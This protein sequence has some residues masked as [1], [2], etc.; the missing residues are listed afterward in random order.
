MGI[1]INS[2]L[3]SS[4]ASE[5]RKAAR[6]LN[7]FTDNGKGM[8]VIIPPH[9]LRDAKGLAIFTV[10][11]AGFLFSGRAGSGLVVARLSDG[12]WSAPSAILTGGMGFGG[13]VGAELTDFIMV[14]NTTAAVKTFMHHG[15]ITL[16]GNISV[17][18]GPVGRNA[19]AS[20]TASIKSIAA[21]YS[22]SKTRGLFAGVS[23]EGSVILERFDANKKLYGHKVQVRDLLNGSIPPPPGADVLYRALEIK[24]GGVSRER[25]RFM[26]DQYDT[27]SSNQSYDTRTDEW[28]S[29]AS[30]TMSLSRAHVHQLAK[31]GG[32]QVTRNHTTGSAWQDNSTSDVSS[33]EI[34]YQERR[35]LV[36][37]RQDVRARALFNFA[38]EQEGDLVFHKGDMITIVKKTDTQNDW[39]T[40][41]IGNRQGIFPAN[42]VQLV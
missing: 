34:T 18:A 29:P 7:S 23:L 4:L 39:W 22:Y 5:C 14:L 13:Q 27:S 42:F 35:A 16:G 41:R 8:D 25:F 2:P 24:S 19:E 38:G 6:I 9:I 11:K 36:P 10:L 33:R 15:S 30:R 3:P 37:S 12:S 28:D 17:A 32:P 31:T 21:V 40:G 20:G 26:E 1:T